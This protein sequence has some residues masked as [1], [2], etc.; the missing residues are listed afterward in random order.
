[1]KTFINE[2]VREVMGK[3]KY[4]PIKIVNTKSIKNTMEYELVDHE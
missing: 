1:M 4:G 2:I 3:S